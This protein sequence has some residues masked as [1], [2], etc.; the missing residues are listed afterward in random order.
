MD[1]GMSYEVG[2][3]SG[4]VV[5]IQENNNGDVIGL[6]ISALQQ[7]HWAKPC[8]VWLDMETRQV[9]I[10]HHC[11][12]GNCARFDGPALDMAIRFLKSPKAPLGVAE[13][14]LSPDQATAWKALLAGTE[15]D[16]AEI[17][18]PSFDNNGWK[19]AYTQFGED[20]VRFPY[21]LDG[22]LFLVRIGNATLG[23]RDS[24]DVLVSFTALKDGKVVPIAGVYVE[25]QRTGPKSII[26]R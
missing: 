10:E 19:Q 5:T 9:A 25:K 11:S 2:L 7:R 13:E 4:R 21:L 23:W 12:D 15:A 14:S 24:N 3:L 8:S 1:I 22:Q 26:V 17:E 20:S 16:A 18:M 6:D